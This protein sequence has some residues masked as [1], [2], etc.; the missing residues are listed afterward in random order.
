[1]AGKSPC[2]NRT[3]CWWKSLHHL[4]CMKPC[5]NGICTISTQDS[6][7]QRYIFIYGCFLINLNMPLI[8]AWICVVFIGR[9]RWS[10]PI[11]LKVQCNISARPQAILA[12]QAWLL[13]VIIS[14]CFKFQPYPISMFFLATSTTIGGI[15]QSDSKLPVYRWMVSAYKPFS[16]IF[17]IKYLCSLAMRSI[18]Y[19]KPPHV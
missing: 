12:S 11:D 16:H 13:G 4:L 10:Q 17:T 14:T 7:H 6:V 18:I 9:T 15:L 1:M 2:F 3:Y 19:S 8:F 5:E